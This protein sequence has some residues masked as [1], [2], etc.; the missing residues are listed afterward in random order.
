M[1]KPKKSSRVRQRRVSAQKLEQAVQEV[2]ED[3]QDPDLDAAEV[4]M[5]LARLL[6]EEGNG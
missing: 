3:R 6:S 1:T 4:E 5:E 2:L